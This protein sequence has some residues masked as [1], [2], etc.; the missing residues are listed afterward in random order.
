MW[1]MYYDSHVKKN[2]DVI[3]T[4]HMLAGSKY[5]DFMKLTQMETAHCTMLVLATHCNYTGC[6]KG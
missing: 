3:R 1:F 5:Y 6:C 2:N 4:L